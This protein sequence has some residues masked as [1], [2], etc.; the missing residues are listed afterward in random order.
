MRGGENV[1]DKQIEELERLAAPL[2]AWLAENFDPYTAVVITEE[3]VALTQELMG[4]PSP[5]YNSSTAPGI[6]HIPTCE[7]VN[8]LKGREGVETHTVGPTASI[9]VQADG[10]AVVLSVI[11]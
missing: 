7:L 2:V 3:R 4:I 10:P 6:T 11:D 1:A 8:E 9:T 5:V